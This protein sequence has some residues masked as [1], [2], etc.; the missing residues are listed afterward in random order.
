MKTVREV[1]QYKGSHVF[2]ISP[3]TTVFEALKLMAEK[4]I[5]ALIVTE[6][7]RVLGIMS[8]RDYA[9]KVSLLGKFTRDTAVEEIMSSTIFYVGTDSHID[10][11]M[12]IM[13]NKRIRHLPVME[14]GKLVGLISIG[15]VVK[16][17]IDEREFVIDQ[18]IHY[19]SGKPG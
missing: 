3:K 7:D 12:A 17:V 16:A 8:E 13:I 11:C 18:L 19:I 1:L 10:E 2:T 4:N 15:D 6:K 9:R 14:D 5:G